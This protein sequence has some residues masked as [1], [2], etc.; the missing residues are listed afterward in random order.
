MVGEQRSLTEKLNDKL[1]KT[2]DCWVYRN[3]NTSNGYAQMC[4]SYDPFTKQRY[5]SPR[6]IYAHRIA[7]A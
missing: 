6:N 5:P 3:A 2:G 4:V 1:D 7:W